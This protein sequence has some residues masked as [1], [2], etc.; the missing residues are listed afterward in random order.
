MFATHDAR[1]QHHDQLDALLI[2]LLS[3]HSLPALLDRLVQCNV[4]AGNVWPGTQTSQHPQLLARNLYEELEHPVVGRHS[5]VTT[6]FLSR[7][8]PCWLTMPAPVSGAG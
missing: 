3:S 5:L 7:H 6:P 2:E 1:W 4:P 8:T